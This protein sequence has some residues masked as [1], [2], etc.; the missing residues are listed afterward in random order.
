MMKIGKERDTQKKT[1][2]NRPWFDADQA[3]EYLSMTRAA[4]Y[5]AARRGQ[6]P[7]YRLGTRLRFRR[8]DLDQLLESNRV[9]TPVDERI[10]L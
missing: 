3:G 6:L 10:S 9:L 1:L 2:E 4:I 5:Q 7:C 8:E